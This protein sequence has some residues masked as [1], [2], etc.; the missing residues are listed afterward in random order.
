MSR[1]QVCGRCVL[2][3][4]RGY[5]EDDEMS[6][7]GRRHKAG[8]RETLYLLSRGSCYAPDCGQPVVRMVDDEPC[9][10]VQTAHIRGL[11]QGSAR[12]DNG[13][14]APRRNEFGNLLL[15]CQAHHRA[16]DDKSKETRYTVEV[17][18]AWKRKREGERGDQI[19]D[20]CN[21]GDLE[22][23]LLAAVTDTKTD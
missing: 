13:F 6:T 20:L 1:P 8:V 2:K 15:L 5:G 18:L 3:S 14:P 10:N 11:N 4:V 22:R 19:A 17:L 7:I 23:K 9:L 12:F 21:D 16:V